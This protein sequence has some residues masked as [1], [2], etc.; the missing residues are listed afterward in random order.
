MNNEIENKENK[1]INVELLFH[2]NELKTKKNAEIVVK[3]I[4]ELA[5]KYS[6]SID[7]VVDIFTTAM[8]TYENILIEYLKTRK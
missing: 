1:Q 2:L 4:F 6:L 5:G 7:V 3:K 8:D